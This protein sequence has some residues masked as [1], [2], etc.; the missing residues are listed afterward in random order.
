MA[1]ERRGC[2]RSWAVHDLIPQSPGLGLQPPLH[3]PTFAP[4]PG[5]PFSLLRAL[6]RD[7]PIPQSSAQCQFVLTP[8][9]APA[10]TTISVTC[11]PLAL[12][13]LSATPWV[14]LVYYFSFA[15][16][17]TEAWSGEV[18]GQDQNPK[19]S[20]PGGTASGEVGDQAGD[21]SFPLSLG[22]R[23]PD[24]TTGDSQLSKIPSFQLRS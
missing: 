4:L 8:S 21:C 22:S 7:S 13:V 10:P 18:T 2:L 17:D 23:G 9:L 19:L 15:S 6:T 5:T 12:A 1:S 14:P 20:S 16:Q 3:L 24:P 11:L